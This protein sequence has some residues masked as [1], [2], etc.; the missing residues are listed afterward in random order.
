MYTCLRC[1]IVVCL[2]WTCCAWSIYQIC[3]IW[4]YTVTIV[5][6]L[7][8]WAITIWNTIWYWF[9]ISTRA[10]FHTSTWKVV[11]SWRANTNISTTNILKIRTYTCRYISIINFITWTNSTDSWNIKV[12][13]IA[14]TFWCYSIIILIWFTNWLTISWNWLSSSNTYACTIW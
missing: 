12:T 3:S 10:C 5:K 11:I 1:R 2:S 7:V 8:C 9:F 13:E 6:Y 14:L 4:T